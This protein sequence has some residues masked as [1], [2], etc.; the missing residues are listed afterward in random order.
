VTVFRPLNTLAGLSR[1]RAK[2]CGGVDSTL[3]LAIRSGRLWA[4]ASAVFVPASGTASVVR[5]W[6]NATH[7]EKANPLERRGRKAAGPSTPPPQPGSMAAELP[8]GHGD[9]RPSPDRASRSAAARGRSDPADA[10]SVPTTGQRFTPLA[11]GRWWCRANPD[12]KAG[13]SND[14]PTTTLAGRVRLLR[15]AL[16]SPTPAHPPSG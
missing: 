3:V 11:R 2:T 15:S 10:H 16:C 14:I 5:P 12:R 8:K 7:R 13:G 6:A 9:R 1:E 4:R